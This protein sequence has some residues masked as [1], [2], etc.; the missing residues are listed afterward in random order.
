MQLN[1]GYLFYKL[2]MKM[3]VLKDYKIHKSDYRTE[4]KKAHNGLKARG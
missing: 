4:P 3:C 1:N 2:Q